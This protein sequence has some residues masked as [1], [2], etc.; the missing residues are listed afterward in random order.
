MSDTLTYTKSDLI[1]LASRVAAVAHLAPDFDGADPWGSAM[2]VW[3]ACADHLNIR[4]EGI[5]GEWEFRPGLG[6]DEPDPLYIDFASDYLV[7]LGN[8]AMS[9][10]DT[11]K[12]L[13]LSY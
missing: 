2:S 1:R 12:G 13:G 11:C 6:L 10:A 9:L 7:M 8:R 4:D 5:P 3:F